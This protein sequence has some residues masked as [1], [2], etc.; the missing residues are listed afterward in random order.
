ML[1]DVLEE[2]DGA[3]QLPAI[4]GLGGL[5]SVLERHSE[6]LAAGA[7]RLGGRNLGGGVSNL[8]YQRR[9]VSLESPHGKKNIDKKIVEVEFLPRDVSHPVRIFFSQYWYIKISKP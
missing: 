1:L 2:G 5:T 9:P 3:G 4:D 6:V 7:S 8:F